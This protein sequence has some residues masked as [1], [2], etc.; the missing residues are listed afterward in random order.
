MRNNFEKFV[1][2]LG[3]GLYTDK[4]AMIEVKWLESEI[5]FFKGSTSTADRHSIIRIV[6]AVVVHAQSIKIFSVVI[7]GY[8]IIAGLKGYA[9]INAG[10]FQSPL[11]NAYDKWPKTRL[12]S[13]FL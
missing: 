13:H 9:S 10:F 7:C 2:R 1:F 11:C 3:M 4:M 12:C 8:E 6:Y 5:L